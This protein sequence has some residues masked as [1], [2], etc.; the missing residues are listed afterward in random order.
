M[1]RSP[2]VRVTLSDDLLIHLRKT[3]Q[4]QH[5]S[6]RWLVAGLVCDTLEARTEHHEEVTFSSRDDNRRILKSLGYAD[7]CRMQEDDAAMSTDHTLPFLARGLLRV[8]AANPEF[9]QLIRNA[10]IPLATDVRN[11]RN[12][13][14]LYTHR[15]Q[16]AQR[17]TG[18]TRNTAEVV[19]VP[20]DYE[21]DDAE[22]LGELCKMLKGLAAVIDE[23]R[24]ISKGNTV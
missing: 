18:K 12:S 17:M 8:R 22:V 10:E 23:P 14:V 13:C 16:A 5:V 11:P 15:T 19:A 2:Q 24:S 6:L 9:Q 4:V 3:A 7:R 20:V 1:K 21:T